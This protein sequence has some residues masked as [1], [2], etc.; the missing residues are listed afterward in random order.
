M[1]VKEKRP[2]VKAGNAR[3]LQLQLNKCFQW[4][5]R[6]FNTYRYLTKTILLLAWRRMGR[7]VKKEC[8]HKENF[9]QNR[10]F[11]TY[12]YK[13]SLVP[14]RSMTSVMLNTCLTQRVLADILLPE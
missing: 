13:I 2:F 6:V 11:Q 7:E 4:V 1:F 3:S 8:P 5:Y 12:R 9:R 10:F 14:M